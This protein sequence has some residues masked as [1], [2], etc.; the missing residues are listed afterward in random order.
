MKEIHLLWSGNE[1]KKNNLI[2]C[3]DKAVDKNYN[4][5]ENHSQ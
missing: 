4:D 5:I 3:V 2:F 1:I